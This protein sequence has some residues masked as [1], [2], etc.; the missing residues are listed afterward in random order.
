MLKPWTGKWQAGDKS[1]SVKLFDSRVEDM[2]NIAI[3]RRKD[4]R[5]NKDS[6]KLHWYF[7][8]RECKHWSFGGQATLVALLVLRLGSLQAELQRK[9]GLLSVLGTKCFHHKPTSR[10]LMLKMWLGSTAN[11]FF[12][13]TKSQVNSKPTSAWPVKIE[14]TAGCYC[15]ARRFSA[16][17]G[18][19]YSS[20]ML[21][22]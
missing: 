9:T 12:F 13:A 15:F 20:C 14:A 22:I 11:P 2:Q 3:L 18:F 17:T 1:A 7:S 10:D 8:K 21:M 19:G 5:V 6:H 16:M 4:R